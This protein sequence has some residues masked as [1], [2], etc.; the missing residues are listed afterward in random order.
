M[1]VVVA[2]VSVHLVQ[3]G[4]HR[5]VL[6]PSFGKS[7]ISLTPP[8]GCCS[9]GEGALAVEED[10]RGRLIVAGSTESEGLL[11]RRF[12]HDGS[13]D[14]SFGEDGQVEATLG[15]ETEGWNVE[16]LPRGEILVTGSTERGFVLARYRSDGSPVRSFG[17]EGRGWVYTPGGLEGAGAFAGDVQRN[18][19]ILVGG[20][21]ID[22]NRKWYERVIRYRL[23]GSID[24]SF[25]NKGVFEL[26]P[27]KGITGTITG[28]EVLP[29]GKILLGGHIG[30][31]LMLA[32]LHPSGKPDFRFGR[33]GDGI[34]LVDI[35][36]VRRCNCGYAEALEISPGGKPLLAG[37][38]AAGKEPSLLARFTPD[39]R[40][41]R[42]FGNGG[43]V[44]T[45]RGTRLAFRDITLQRNG[46]ITATGY[47]NEASSGEVQVAAL[48]YLPNGKLDRGF[49]Q[50]GF[51]HRHFGRESVGN[52]AITQPDGSVVVAGRAI[53]GEP[54]SEAPHP[55]EGGQV[56][57][58]RFKR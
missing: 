31:Y 12:H 25:A 16:L 37:G 42:S 4:E 58:M 48:R 40:L 50:G 32:R 36:G 35:D 49:A 45:L 47:Y 43:V 24:K 26:R 17:G 28:I 3:A 1:S 22:H 27:P 29:S 20:Y 41:D 55:L 38:V 13:P 52:A 51:F 21:R 8:G 39:G 56:L 7:G 5:K 54:F 6:D 19:R 14:S 11:V 34:V 18:G 46:R 10:P 57:M 53:F 2:L 33:A 30:G 9:K 15:G 23:D 44:R